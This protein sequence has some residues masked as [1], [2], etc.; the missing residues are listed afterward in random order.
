MFNFGRPKTLG[1]WIV[2]IAG[3]I[4]ALITHLVDA[5]DL[6]ALKISRVK[7]TGRTSP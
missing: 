3:G 6:C 7:A 1:D 2:H 4:V 5:A